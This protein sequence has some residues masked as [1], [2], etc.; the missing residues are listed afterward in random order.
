MSKTIRANGKERSPLGTKNN[1]VA[2]PDRHRKHKPYGYDSTGSG[3][4]KQ[5][6]WKNGTDPDEYGEFAS[7]QNKHKARNDWKKQ[8]E[9]ELDGNE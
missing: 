8:I 2:R 4:W 7:V 5:C 1:R 3:D 9:Q 6:P